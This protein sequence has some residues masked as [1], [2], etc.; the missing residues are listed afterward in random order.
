MAMFCPCHSAAKMRGGL[1]ALLLVGAMTSPALAQLKPEAEQWLTQDEARAALLGVDMDGY[2]PSSKMAWREC[3]DPQGTTLYETP[4]GVQNGVLEVNAWGEACFAYDD[5][6]YA[7]W[8]CFRVR[9]TGTGIVFENDFGDV[10]VT[11]S[12]VRGVR[13]CRAEL[14]G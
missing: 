12:L 5:D 1:L 10:F 3:I 2:S 7:S 11:T 4:F 14:I 13:T 8:Q 6:D 9:L